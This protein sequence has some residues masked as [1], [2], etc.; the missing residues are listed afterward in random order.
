MS[1]RLHVTKMS[2]A[3]ND[4]LV[5][6]AEAAALAD[7]R[8]W[9]RRVCRR[10]VSVGADGVLFVAR[11]AGGRIRVAF[12]N[13]DG[14]P[15]FCGNGSRCA[16]RFAR[17]NG[18]AG[19]S[20][21]LETTA[22][23]VEAEVLGERVK[24]RLPPPTDAGQVEI[25]IGPERLVG[26]SIVAGVPHFVTWVGEVA[27]APLARWG[28]AV[29]RHPRFAPAGVNVDLVQ[30]DSAEQLRLRTW[31]RGV[32]GETLSCGSGAVAAAF[33]SR[34]NGGAACLTALPASGIALEIRLPGPPD[35]PEAAEVI[36]DA[37]VI[38]VGELDP[39]ASR[40]FPD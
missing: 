21:V 27:T 39:E 12:R 6:G 23:E 20:M 25:D 17:L 30:V 26:R 19:D 7:D 40:G 34:L 1:G 38:F 5:L 2:G 15:A 33:A 22:G 9:I 16:A 13:P 31:E 3:G 10:G 8:G 24:L 14:S 11:G 4:F 32:E 35:R 36:G 18:L 28:P 29:R 37:R